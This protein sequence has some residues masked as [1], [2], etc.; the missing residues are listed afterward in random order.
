MPT[1]LE[2]PIVP[3]L[4]WAALP[5]PAAATRA[6]PADTIYHGGKIV[7]MNGEAPTYAEAVAVKDGRIVVVGTKAEALR[8][9]GEAT[10]VRDLGGNALLPGFIDA[11]SHFLSRSTWSTR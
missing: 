8:R 6:Q 7:T 3:A 4:V 9:K 5:M 2:I 11:N 1:R 10:Q